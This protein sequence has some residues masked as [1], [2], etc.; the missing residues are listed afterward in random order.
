MLVKSMSDSK[1]QYSRQKELD[2][3]RTADTVRLAVLR[4]LV[5]G[6]SVRAAARMAGSSKGAVLRL[7]AEVGEFCAVYQDYRLRNL[8][9]TR[10]EADEIWSYCGTKQRHAKHSGEGDLWTFCALDADRK[11]VVSWLVGA[12]S[13]ENT[14]AFMADV[15]SRLRHRVQ[16]TTDGFGP[17]LPAVR[18]AFPVG[19]ID[20]A[21]LIKEYGHGPEEAAAP[22]RRY[23]PQICIWH[24]ED[25]SYRPP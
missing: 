25:S 19:R 14:N 10:L 20:F 23:S 11:L 16:L 12:R 2:V 6:A 3:N 15:A 9:T 17:Y 4:A 21:Q 18:R 13:P 5:D 7:L 8:P 22:A 1:L 24:H